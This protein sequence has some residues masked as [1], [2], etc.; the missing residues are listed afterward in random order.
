[1]LTKSISLSGVPPVE[2]GQ[3]KALESFS[4]CL[5]STYSMEMGFSEGSDSADV[6]EVVDLQLL[7]QDLGAGGVGSDGNA[8]RLLRIL[9]EF[10]MDQYQAAEDIDAV[11]SILNDDD[12][13]DAADNILSD[14]EAIDAIDAID[15]IN[16]AE[17]IMSSDD[18]RY[19]CVLP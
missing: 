15:A 4:L 10:D 11:D 18:A 5:N 8:L 19:S 9:H 7:A 13:I 14:D 3:Q 2:R 17:N 6:G 1:M 12:G 16:A